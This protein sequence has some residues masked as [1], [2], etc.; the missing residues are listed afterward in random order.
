[1][2]NIENKRKA[3][4]FSLKIVIVIYVLGSL[5]NYTILRT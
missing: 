2:K 4:L 3:S 5:K 1:M